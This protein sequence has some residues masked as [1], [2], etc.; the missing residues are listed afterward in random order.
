MIRNRNSH[1]AIASR[2]EDTQGVQQALKRAVTET[3]R[4]H[5]MSGHKIVFWRD[6]QIVWEEASTNSIV[7]GQ[8]EN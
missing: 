1:E 4:E 5:A 2:T 3:I 8:T 6:N 7:D